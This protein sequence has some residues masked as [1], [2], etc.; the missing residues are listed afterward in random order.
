MDSVQLPWNQLE[1]LE[2]RATKM[3]YNYKIK[4]LFLELGGFWG[5]GHLKGSILDISP[6]FYCK[7]PDILYTYSVFWTLKDTAMVQR[8]GFTVFSPPHSSL[9]HTEVHL[10]S[11]ESI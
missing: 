3:A 7:L 10:M 8:I 4:G 9:A 2:V 11:S 6:L 5:W 1:L